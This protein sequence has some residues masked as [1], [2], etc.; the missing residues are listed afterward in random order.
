M[1]AIVPEGAERAQPRRV[2]APQNSPAN[3]APHRM[4]R[5]ADRLRPISSRNAARFHQSGAGAGHPATISPN[6][7]EELMI[8]GPT[9]RV[10]KA[11]DIR[12]VKS[13]SDRRTL[14]AIER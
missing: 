3:G 6:V 9:E 7:D 10:F 13:D 5:H 2:S 4:R 12:L 14:I 8:V 11:V 1:P